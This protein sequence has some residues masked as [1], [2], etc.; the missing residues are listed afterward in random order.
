[1]KISN[2]IRA[3]A[4]IVV[5]IALVLAT[6]AVYWPAKN[7]DFVL[8]DDDA[9][10]MSNPNFRKGFSLGHV[11]CIVAY[12]AP[13]EEANPWHPLTTF[14]LMLDHRLYGLRPAG[15][16]VTNVVLHIANAL[17]LF[18][19]FARMTHTVWRSAFVAALFA[20]HPLHVE[21]VAWA[22]ERKDVLSTLFGMLAIGSYVLYAERPKIG[23]YAGVCPLF[24][25]SLMAKTMLV[26]LPFVLLLFD[27]WPLKRFRGSPQIGGGGASP[28]PAQ[29]QPGRKRGAKQKGGK[30]PI[31][32]DKAEPQGGLSLWLLVREKIPLFALSAAAAAMNLYSQAQL[33]AVDAAIPLSMRIENAVVSYA[34]YILK[35]LRPVDLAVLYPY[36]EAIHLWKFAAALAFLSL[37]TAF[38]LR[39]ACRL[40]WLFVGWFLYLGTLVPV[41]GIIQAGRQAMADRYTYFPLIG[42]FIIAAWGA[43]RITRN[44][45]YR[46]VLPA[47]AV[48]VL[49]L[50]SVAARQQVAFWKDGITLFEH[51]LAVTADNGVIR[52]CLADT[53]SRAGRLDEAVAHYREA[54]RLTPGDS[55]MW[56]NLGHA[57]HRQGNDGEAFECFLNA[58]RANPDNVKALGNVGT[59]LASRGRVGEAEPYFEKALRIRP[60]DLEAGIGRAEVLQAMGRRDEALALYERMLILHGDSAEVNYNA[61]TLLASYGR[62]DEALDCFR[63]AVALKPGYAKA[64][65]NLGSALM[66]KGLPDEAAVHFRAAVQTDPG[67]EAAKT[68]LAEAIRIGKQRGKGAFRGR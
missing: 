62:F 21:S 20:L 44:L 16:H 63:K 27:F 36:P 2:V 3:K 60:D 67:F 8:L 24:A 49:L 48:I 37:V 57:L 52:R 29:A 64:H 12:C 13:A 68:N 34:A 14:S 45:C 66:L 42:L 59:M 46:K 11:A 4:K 41:I 40:P 51:A 32:G 19:I 17:L 31:S 28:A 18:L 30:S 54:A 39:L 35:M 58:V 25:L 43:A 10:I 38:A 56:N 9:Y 23:R 47:A 1:M 65:N 6:A 15:Y 53:L 7:H 55:E 5:C 26:T 22:A 50:L 33:G 61:G